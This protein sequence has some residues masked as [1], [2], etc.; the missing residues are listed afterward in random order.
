[1][2][3]DVT[4]T[5]KSGGKDVTKTL[6]AAEMIPSREALGLW[7]V[8]GAAWKVYATTKQYQ[9]SSDDYR[10]ANV[11][12]GL[13]MGDPKFQQ[14]TVKQ[15]TRLASQGFALIT[16]WMD[17][18]NF[19][20]T[21]QISGGCAAANTVGLRYFQGFIKPGITEPAFG[22]SEQAA[23]LVDAIVAWGH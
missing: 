6:T 8:D 13:P 2:S 5:Y 19:Q 11:A 1:M 14:G 9:A 23:E 3:A 10:L 22:H 18:T 7:R 12:A 17:G 21:V 16:Q 20:E 15:G 4:F